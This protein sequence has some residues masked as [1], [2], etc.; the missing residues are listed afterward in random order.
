M[1]D[2]SAKQVF[3]TNNPSRW[4][5]V[6]W[7][8]RV[9]II[10]A[11]L[12]VAVLVI[13]VRRGVD[14]SLP[15]LSD[16]YKT[17]L[18][19]D[20]PLY[21][22]SKI[23]KEYK[24]FRQ[25]FTE[26]K[27]FKQGAF[28][29]ADTSSNDWMDILGLQSSSTRWHEFPAGIRSAFYV[30]WDPQSYFSLRRNIGN[31]NLVMPEW[32]FLD[33]NTDS[34]S[35]DV[36]QRGFDLMK[37]SGVK[38]MPMLSNNYRGV[39][40]SASLSRIFRDEN[41][42]KALIANV[43]KECLAN[44]FVGINVDFEEMQEK[45]DELFKTFMKELSAAFKPNGLLITLDASPYNE[46]YDLKELSKYCDYVFLMAYD[47]FSET[48]VP[49]PVS[50]Q[51]WI[52]GAVHQAAK[53]MPA[54][55]IILGLAAYGYDWMDGKQGATVTYQEALTTAKDND[56]FVKYDNDTYN[57]SYDYKDED[58]VHHK[59]YFTDAATNFNS[60]RF[61]TEYGLAG[62]AVWRL[63]SEDSRIWDFYSKDM[64]KEFISKLNFKEFNKVESSTDVDYIGEG[65]VL[66]I[67]ATPKQGY[68]TPTIDTA[69]MLIAE[70]RYDSLPSMFVVKRYG[71]AQPKQLLLTF[72]D[73]PDPTYTPQI[74]DI[75]SKY[76]VPAAFFLVGLNIENNL[77]IV[78]RI[79]REG[80]EIGNHTFTHPNIAEVSKYRAAL[81]MKLTRLLIECITGHSTIY[82]RAPYNA[83]SEPESMQE[84]VPVQIARERNYLDIGES[85]DPEDWQ[86]GVSADTIFKRVVDG[87]EAPNARD[88]RIVLLHDAGGDS[89]K[90]TVLALPKIIEYFQKKGYTFVTVF[91]ILGKTKDQVMPPVP[92][93]S[94]YYLLQI[95]LVLAEIG[96]WGGH[97]LASAFIVFMVLSCIRLI[98]MG[99][100]AGRE[101]R[102]ERKIIYPALNT[103]N[104]P[105]VS[106]IVPA[107]NEEVNAV[108]SIH[109]LLRQSYPNFNIIFVDDGSKDATIERVQAAF[110][111]NDKVKIFTKINGGKASALNYGITKTDAEFVVCIDADTNLLPDAMAQMMKHY[112]VPTKEGKQVGA[113]AGYVKV[114]NE[115]NLLTRWQAIE[116]I[117]SQNFDRLAFA[118]INAI[119]VVPGAIGAFRSRALVDAGGFTIDTLAEDCDLSIRILRA[120]YII[121]NEQNAVAM[122]EAPESL[123]QFMKQRVR[124]SFGVLQTFWKNRDALFNTK[125]RALGTFALPNI[126]LFQFIIPFFSPLAD[127][128]M[129][130]G[131]IS[132][133]GAKIGKY[134]LIFMAV[135]AGIAIM[136][137]FLSKESM[138]RL[139]W[140][141]PQRLGYRWIMYVV[142]YRSMKK[143]IKG[144]L[145]LWGVL[146]RTGN[147]KGMKDAIN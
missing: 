43:L 78:K 30:A 11:T 17:A 134:Y 80:H 26:K 132:G 9:L 75:L 121:E 86:P 56:A 100:L 135:D 51:K 147:M 25:Y 72:D 42:R 125:Y 128:F 2:T 36:D 113:V 101:H 12:L 28:E 33:P 16:A 120:G 119:T 40:Q 29:P 60:I 138:R 48:S 21:Q 116:Y 79:Y 71:R 142:L 137:F 13:T 136:A 139:I 126:L 118:N 54:N 70:E 88:G 144:E 68:I 64:R 143:A 117:S 63:G 141:I 140:L 103:V 114:G 106:I 8:S 107:F 50:S 7:G 99:I 5:S 133:N 57:L 44:K 98:I 55:K 67:V 27:P 66:D 35:R 52:E 74:L 123:R 32:F 89:R 41:K 53:Q 129:I 109:N 20:K 69:E 76:H 3:Q 95:N 14:P 10:I 6:K 83:D 145:Q 49:G 96:Y 104:C 127:I 91:S 82:F 81:E 108:A 61:A 102:K 92:R 112:L 38:I 18:T 130:I 131:I 105:A 84:M 37:R 73:G 23:S 39:F 24:G 94:G 4:Q 110:S 31:L 15:K 93:G 58:S 1:S 87:V 90:Q 62:A 22:E 122:T 65:E 34:I 47:E 46:D 115:V 124:W 146:K 97:F 111:G 19:A 45:S 85:I 77:P 59:V